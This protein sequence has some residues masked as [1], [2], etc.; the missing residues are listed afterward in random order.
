MTIPHMNHAVSKNSKNKVSNT[1][2]ST[3]D[4]NAVKKQPDEVVD[5]GEPLP[6]KLKVPLAGFSMASNKADNREYA[7]A[8]VGQVA[9]MELKPASDMDPTAVSAASAASM[10]NEVL[11]PETPQ[12]PI[13]IGKNTSTGVFYG[14]SF[15]KRESLNARMFLK[16]YGAHEFLDT[17]LP[18]ELNSLYVYYLIKLLG[19]EVKDQALI[20]NINTIVHTSTPENIQD[21]ENTISATNVEDPLAKKQTVRLIKDLQRAIN[22]VLCT[23]LRLSNFFTIDHFIQKLHTAKRILVLTGAGVSTSL[24][25]PDFRSSEGFYSKIKHLGLDDPQDVFNYN[26]FMHDPSIFYNIANMVLPPENIYSPLHS[27]IKMLQTKGKLLRNYTQNIDNL[28]S[29]AGINADRLVQCHGSFATATCVTC[30]W[31]LPGERIFNKIRNLEL[32]LCPYC[33]KKRR[34]YF[35]EGYNSTSD[36]NKI[37]GTGTQDSALARPS[38]IL[39]SY[40]V[41]KPDI[42]FFGE[43]LPNKFHKSIREDILQCDLLICI[44]TSLK[45]APVSEI[46]NMIPAHVPQVLINR[47][48]VKHAEFDLS[49]LGYCDDIAAMVAQRCGWAIPHKKWNDLKTKKFDCRE[50]DKGL[51]VITSDEHPGN[52]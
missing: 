28:E 32:P 3:Q 33:Y 1:V 24:G 19:F 8:A 31:N 21:S 25:I 6:K 37:S 14:P 51:Y 40:G 29:Y 11:K 7:Q 5:S 13:I 27:F 26:I 15:T 30:H 20:R 49:L 46:V 43:A 47:D 39:N 44:G 41:L 4:Q 52:L 10:S 35:P 48:P 38:Y 36:S 9:S 22:K 45:V 50:K 12:G 2:S 23:R 17:Y 18:E 34:E 16:Y 42:T